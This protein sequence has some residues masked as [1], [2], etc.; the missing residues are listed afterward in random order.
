MEG[1]PSRLDSQANLGPFLATL[2]ARRW[3]LI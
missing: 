1:N 3:R 2:Y